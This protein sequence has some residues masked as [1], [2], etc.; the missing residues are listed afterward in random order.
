M[1]RLGILISFYNFD[2]RWQDPEAIF[3]ESAALLVCYESSFNVNCFL[4]EN[5]AGNLISPLHDIP[6]FANDSKQIYNMVV[7]V[8]R[9]TNAKME[10]ID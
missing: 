2:R 3:S 1:S 8:P 4:L 9:W 7:E 6:L 5:A 10:V